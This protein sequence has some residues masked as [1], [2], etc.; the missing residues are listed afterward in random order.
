MPTISGTLYFDVNR[1]NSAQTAGAPIANVAIVLQN[2]ASQL[3]LAI[4]TDANGR[5]TFN[6]VPN[7]NY[8]IVESYG[9][10]TTNPTPGDF[11]AATVAPL[12]SGGRVPPIS[13]VPTAPKG[14][15]HL[16]CTKRN[17][18]SVTV[19][20]AN[21][22]AQDFMNG[23]VTYTPISTIMD[24][25]AVIS[26]TNIFTEADNG[27]FGTFA[28]GTNG[29]T[30]VSPKPYQF[31][32]DFTYV[33]PNTAVTTPNDGQFTIQNIM[34]NSHANTAGTWWRVA[35]RSYGNEIGRLM[36]V[37]GSDPGNIIISQQITVVPNTNYL[38]S[39]WILNMCKI[40]TGY[41]NPQLGVQILD[42]AGT[43]IYSATLG[44]QIPVNPV[45]P[46]WKQIGTVINSQGNTTITVQFVSMG[47]AATG[48][49][50]AID[51]ISLSMIQVPTYAPSKSAS[52][53]T[54]K[55]GDTFDYTITMNNPGVAPITN[56]Y[57]LDPLPSGL[58]FVL[59]SVL[60][61]NVSTPNVDPNVGFQTPDIPA[62]GT[63]T[64]TFT[65][66][67]T[68]IPASN[69]I[70][71]SAQLRYDYTPVD[72]GIAT[73]Y[74]TISN[75]VQV[76]IDAADA[77]LSILKTATPATIQAGQTLTYTI[78]ITNN[79]PNI[80]ENPLLID[81]VPSELKNP[82]Y[83]IDY[84]QTWNVGL[85]K[86]GI[87]SL[88]SGQTY[89]VLVKGV[90][91]QY[92]TTPIDNTASIFSATHDP[93]LSNN[94]STITT[95]VNSS[96]DLSL[97]KIGTPSQVIAGNTLNYTL[98]ISNTGPR[99][100]HDV[101]LTDVVSDMILNPKFSL[102][103][104]VTWQPWENPYTLG[105]LA[106]G[107]NMTVLI[108]GSVAANTTAANIVNTAAISSS[109]FDPNL[110]N[111][112]STVNTSVIFE[113]DV[114][115]T[116]TADKNLVAAGDTLTYTLTATNA[117]P[118]DAQ[119]TAINDPLP[120]D[121]L[122]ARYSDDDGATWHTWTGSYLVGV[123]KP[124]A[125]VKILLSGTVDPNAAGL[126]TNVATIQTATPDPN[127]KDNEATLLT[128]INTSADLAV[129]K[130]ASPSPVKDDQILTYTI[131]TTNNG[132]NAAENV[133]L[134]ENMPPEL[135]NLQFSLD[136][137]VTWAAWTGSYNLGLLDDGATVI[138]LIRGEVN[139]AAVGLITNTVHVSSITPD[140]IPRN[141]TFR[142]MTPMNDPADLAISKTVIEALPVIGG[143]IT[144]LL[145]IANKGDDAAINAILTDDLDPIIQNPEISFDDGQT[146]TSY[147]SPVSLGNILVD[148]TKAV[149]IRGVIDKFTDINL[150]KSIT[151]TAS[152][153]SDTPE[154][155]YDNN[156]ATIT[157]P[158]A[159][160]ADLAI[161]G[162]CLQ[163]ELVAG[164]VADYLVTITNNGP[165]IAENSVLVDNLPATF[166]N[167]EI[168]FDDGQTWQPWNGNTPLG[169]LA[170]GATITALIRRTVSAA[171]TAS[172]ITSQA[173]VHSSTPDPNMQ[174]NTITVTV[175]IIRSATLTINKTGNATVSTGHHLTYTISILNTGPSYVQNVVIDDPLPSALT[176]PE[177]S[178]N[179]GLS[180][181]PWNNSYLVGTLAVG[182][183]AT[184]LVRGIVAPDAPATIFNT[185]TVTSDITEPV[186]NSSATVV[187][188]IAHLT[189]EK[190]VS[191]R[192]VNPGDKIVYTLTL[193]NS[194]PN[195]AQ[196]VSFSDPIPAG[197]S[198]V[199]FSRDGGSTFQPWSGS[200]LL[201]TLAS[202]ATATILIQGI[203]DEDAPEVINNTAT[204]TSPTPDSDP[205]GRSASAS[206]IVQPKS[207]I[208]QITL[209][210][211]PAANAVNPGDKLT[212]TLK[213]INSGP[214]AAQDVLLT[215]KIPA[216]LSNV[217]FSRDGGSTFQ[218]W[219]GSYLLGTLAS[220]TG[221]TILIQ[222]NVDEDAP[223][224]INNTATVTS[225]TPDSDPTRRTASAS[226]IV[227]KYATGADLAVVK[228]A[229]PRLAIAGET[230]TYAIVVTNGGPDIAENVI[231][232]D[233][234][235]KE[236]TNAKYSVDDGQVWKPWTGKLKLNNMSP[237]TSTIILLK[238][239]LS[240]CARKS[241]INI[242]TV[243]SD[244][245]D[246]N[247]YNNQFREKIRVK[248]FHHKCCC[249][250]SCSCCT[251]SWQSQCKPNYKC[252]C[253][254]N[255]KNKSSSTIYIF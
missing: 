185:A 82:L 247:E 62:G 76:T 140:P 232:Q 121:L 81:T 87:P 168:S 233:C 253:N 230:I 136:D 197:L 150:V 99:D 100:A 10:Q 117:G 68:S 64:V 220:G 187:K 50:Y 133:V 200:Y 12:L 37:N 91:N 245:H 112:T 60:I 146:W 48:N 209:I 154:V 166:L 104:G 198:N 97:M 240:D 53:D 132:P 114:A 15:T 39:S 92:V 43:P 248:K 181:S 125:V 79:G 207:N 205:T 105:T 36:I 160:E 18:L 124:A 188:K 120:A 162:K 85:G 222:G 55:I 151:N 229:C 56:T 107:T 73:T 94:T 135:D 103:N 193:N 149:Y 134:S 191:V 199:E 172:S 164:E 29:N 28:P 158:L 9:Y 110:N 161:T 4:L 67:V 184:I 95:P 89:I 148:E 225:P 157:T 243:T 63:L 20:G 180:W 113:A 173:S 11:A 3:T 14:A 174:N 13:Y 235:P 206:V 24:P 142:L 194:G 242:A 171:T 93:D 236:F 74:T 80:A 219:S 2:T 147:L 204:V 127:P 31:K 23:P 138:V 213:V 231:L 19:A 52:V 88:A 152:V 208:A 145:N 102:D 115:I 227:K 251:C 211:I 218:P 196:D 35:D 238:A 86:L 254:C 21:L 195:D 42:S 129:T 26:P 175:P 5:Y 25:N 57:F 38:F 155:N 130:S 221:T 66:S 216:G 139:T 84:G 45:N 202:G 177:Y 106:S 6:N 137:G 252:S 78:T 212:Y 249:S 59:N 49:D 179:G 108:S 51:D 186:S 116:K 178:T 228:I 22:T 46:E 83:S 167:P 144:Y 44:N 111:N 109:T 255:C 201:G 30:G 8:Q 131:T 190:L 77:D 217:E 90:V 183:P 1:T 143:T 65:V 69:P 237:N 32:T 226:V 169:N 244:T 123:L 192:L 61:N 119:N 98:I 72:G 203:V 153:D 96:A 126:L 224:V 101:V 58:S 141:N 54:A 16:D 71:N 176:N 47:P 40:P 7:G 239:K 128:P 75:N 215:D 41:A 223:E 33:L 241:I 182:G 156:T 163:S 122:D 34:N 17:T 27:T 246:P 70:N 118:S 214:A 189:L 250:C 165:S 170:P 159:V 234:L 210:K